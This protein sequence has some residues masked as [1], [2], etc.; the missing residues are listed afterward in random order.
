MSVLSLD[1]GIS[2]LAV[3]PGRLLKNSLSS[4]E[5]AGVRVEASSRRKRKRINCY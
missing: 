1:H 3:S 5:R 4:W 2:Y